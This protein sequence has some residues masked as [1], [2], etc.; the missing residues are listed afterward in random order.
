MF[1]EI[2]KNA[3]MVLRRSA[4]EEKRRQAWL[5]DDGGEE[6]HDG[7]A[8][9]NNAGVAA[10]GSRKDAFDCDPDRFCPPGPRPP[11][12]KEAVRMAAWTQVD[13]MRTLLE[14]H[15]DTARFCFLFRRPSLSLSR[16]CFCAAHAA[17][18]K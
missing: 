9:A 4:G 10:P 6:E 15:Y 1:D 13:E 14:I 2:V 7:A 5:A 16:S 3:E 18:L 8:A 17:D 12:W 11:F